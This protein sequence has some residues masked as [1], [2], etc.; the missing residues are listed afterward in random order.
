MLQLCVA[1]YLISNLLFTFPWTPQPP[2]LLWSD[3]VVLGKRISCIYV[4]CWQPL[5]LAS[6]G[7]VLYLY[8]AG[9]CFFQKKADTRAR[10][11]W[12]DKRKIKAQSGQWQLCLFIKQKTAEYEEEEVRPV[13]T[14][15]TC[16][17]ERGWPA[18]PRK[19]MPRSCEIPNFKYRIRQKQCTS[20]PK[21]RTEWYL[22]SSPAL[23]SPNHFHLR[24]QNE[25]AWLPT[26]APTALSYTP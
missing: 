25:T 12:K 6:L 15:P 17:F 16:V 26:W 24:S 10:L 8:V 20:P 4:S 21:N 3:L 19:D 22:A 7:S 2:V 9:R 5:A 14:V 11:L 23:L 1:K 13:F 18:I